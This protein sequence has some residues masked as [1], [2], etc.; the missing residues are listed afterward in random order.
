MRFVRV[1]LLSLLPLSLFAADPEPPRSHFP[2]D[3]TPS[4]CAPAN[5]CDTYKESELPSAAA[6]FLGLNLDGKWV[7]EHY[8]ELRQAAAP[9]CAKHAT[10]FATPG[11]ARLFCNDLIAPLMRDVCGT[12]FSKDKQPEEYET[13]REFMEIYM[14]GIDQRSKQ[15]WTDAQ[16]CAG[17][18]VTH[19]KPP[20][21]WM[22]PAKIPVGYKG[23][24]T[25][26]ALD[27]D[28]HVPVPA[29]V[30]FEGQIFYANANP[31]GQT[32][33]FYAF[34]LPFAYAERPRPDGHRDLVPPKVTVAAPYYPPLEFPLET[35]T[36]NVIVE[37]NPPADKLKRGGMATINA[38]DATTGKPVELRV[39][40][41]DHQAGDTNHPIAIDWPKKQK[42][43]E[44]WA[45]SLFN[46]YSDVVIAPAAK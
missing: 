30:T 22:E 36:R 45:K 39:F 14:L 35:E 26:Y 34:R 12:K 37:M 9:V 10:C 28:T 7:Q 23:Q 29:R 31:T 41:G 20:I 46:Q 6:R 19:T 32:S 44:I 1:L 40:V 4:L 27:A 13:C 5:S 33:T 42:R 18:P 16:K 38:K 25:F 3:Y 24:V 43:P 11:N 21:V 15:A 8:E 2:N 17:P